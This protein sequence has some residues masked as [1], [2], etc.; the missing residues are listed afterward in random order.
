[1][2][3]RLEKILKLPVY[4]RISI[5]AVLAVLIAVGYYFFL[6]S[7]KAQEYESLRDDYQRLETKLVQ[8]RRIANNLPKFKAEYERMQ[9]QLEEALSQLPN[10]R[11]IPTLLT[12]I[13]SLA[14]DQ[15]L[16]ILRFQ[17]LGE[18]RKDFYAE[19]PVRMNLNGPFHDVVMFF[20][21]VGKLSRIVNISN[22][23]IS[24]QG[25]NIRVEILATTFRFVETN[26]GK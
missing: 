9:Q 3:P 5:A 11:E 25:Q 17:P 1:M 20:D 10:K 12:S 2:D 8:D 23:N 14:K 16:E 7:P 22:L 4:A 24:S 18:R 21:Q 6:Y 15:G 26:K 13:S 19:V